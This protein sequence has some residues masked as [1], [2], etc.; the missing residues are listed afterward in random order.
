MAVTDVVETPDIEAH[1]VELAGEAM[2]VARVL[3][4]T[5]QQEHLGPWRFGIPVPVIE[6]AV[7]AV[8]KGHV[9]PRRK[10]R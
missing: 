3:T 2:V 7:F 10:T 6:R 1:S 5:M 9:T 8:E 4:E